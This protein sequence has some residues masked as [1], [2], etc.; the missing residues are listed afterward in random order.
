MFT[1]IQS[2]LSQALPLR[3]GSPVRPTGLRVG[4][5]RPSRRGERLEVAA[6][7]A[8]RSHSKPQATQRQVRSDSINAC[9]RALQQLQA[10]EDGYRKS[11]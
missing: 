5:G 3:A 2:S 11:R 7:F 6:V 1:G 4:A 8:S 9:F 10:F